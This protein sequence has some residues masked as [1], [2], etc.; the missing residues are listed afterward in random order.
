[1]FRVSRLLR[2]LGPQSGVRNL[3]RVV[4]FSLPAV[5]NIAS[6][7]IMLF[8]T[9]SILGISLFGDTKWR[10]DPFTGDFEAIG[11]Y[12][13]DGINP[14]AN[15]RTFG[16]AFLT[17][18]RCST[19]ENWQNIAADCA[20]ENTYKSPLVSSLFFF[21]FQII[22]QYVTLNLFIA[23]LLDNFNLVKNESKE[24][25]EIKDAMLDFVG[26]WG[27]FDPDATQFISIK[28]LPFLIVNLSPPFG[29]PRDCTVKEVEHFLWET[30]IP[31]YRFPKAKTNN[32]Y[33]KDV[34]YR[35][36]KRAFG[37]VRA[38]ATSRHLDHAGSSMAGKD[39]SKSPAK[40]ADDIALVIEKLR[41]KK[42]IFSTK[43][44][45]ALK[46]LLKFFNKKT[47]GSAFIDLVINAARAN[48]A[49]AESQEAR[50]SDFSDGDMDLFGGRK[51]P[52]SV[53]VKVKLNW[54]NNLID[55]VHHIVGD[56]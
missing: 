30:D 45:I 10:G 34:M 56:H 7:L 15:F 21:S 25:N 39:G 31:I 17:L 33:F 18:F 4:I 5:W 44:M 54:V 23:V 53:A 32:V 46:R 12:Y 11:G 20:E 42:L 2:L 27:V 48:N 16:R 37:D 26:Q 13:S 24:V 51:R 6:L 43:E 29:L 38:Q 40:Q 9:Y 3:I 8:V 35:C 41:E 19:G 1:V 49:K 50:E 22:C 36:C 14:D 52:N 28:Q 47:S 55:H